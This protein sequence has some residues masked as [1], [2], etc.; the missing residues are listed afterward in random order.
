MRRG[1]GAALPAL[2]WLACS[3]GAFADEPGS[4][5]THAADAALERPATSQQ[6]TPSMMPGMDM[7]DA[8]SQHFVWLENLEAVAGTL[9]GGAWDAQAWFGGDLNKLW[10]KSEGDSLDA[11]NAQGKVEALWAHAVL[12]FWDTQLG[13]RHDFGSGPSRD[14]AAFGVQG[15]SPYWFDAEITGYVGEEG[16]TAVRLK[17]EYDL[18]ITQRLVLKPEIELNAY[19]K[20]DRERTLG[21]GLAEGQFELRLRYAFTRRLS[22]Y[23]G[24]VYDSKFAQSASLAR[25]AGEPTVQH[26]AVAGLAFFF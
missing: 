2:Y 4:V 12:P 13:W 19:G 20:P 8:T 14:W 15:I 22:P 3:S 26:R 9:H 24:Y 11:G 16:R 7:D 25:A 23:V 21:A 6:V 5:T 1:A 18:F 10:L 17:T